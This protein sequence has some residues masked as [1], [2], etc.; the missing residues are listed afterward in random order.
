MSAG[1]SGSAGLSGHPVDH[2]GL[3]VLDLAECRRYLRCEQ[4][5][6]VGFVRA[7]TVEILP[8]NYV[9][10]GSGVAFKTGHGSK[11]GA[12]MDGAAVTFEVDGVGL[13]STGVAAWS[14]LVKGVAGLV[15]EDDLL[16]DLEREESLPLL[17]SAARTGRWVLIRPDEI[18]GRAIAAE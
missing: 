2:A 6:R 1:M 11:L 17:P 4:L 9:V 18:S 8:V 5:G 13:P 16:Q 15:T 3:V 14:V 12:A 10:A 7:G